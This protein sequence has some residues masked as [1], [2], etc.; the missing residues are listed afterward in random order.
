MQKSLIIFDFDGTIADTLEVAHL[1]TTELSEEFGFPKLSKTEF[2]ELKGRNIKDVIKMAG[3]SWLQMP[4]LLKRGRELFKK[5]MDK[6]HPVNGMPEI[7][8]VLHDRGYR[9][10]IVT[11]NSEENVRTFLAQYGIRNIEFIYAPNSIFGKAKVLK[12]I[13]KKN[14][15]KPLELM[16]IGDEIRDVEA[17]SK[18]GIPS[19]AVSWGLNSENALK[20]CKPLRLVHFP[21]DLL[22]FFPPLQRTAIA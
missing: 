19:I 16:M 1:I 6:V 3:I 9:M 17:A 18:V 14:S 2:V 21:K 11:S 20:C 4:R 8:E 22:G 13:L 7:I 10:G 5:N 12:R 15:L